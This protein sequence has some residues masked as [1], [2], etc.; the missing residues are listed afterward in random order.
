MIERKSDSS[1]MCQERPA[2]TDDTLLYS[3][4]LLTSFT[5]VFYHLKMT[6]N[7]E[8]EEKACLTA[9]KPQRLLLNTVWQTRTKWY[10]SINRAQS[11]RIYEKNNNKC[12]STM[13]VNHFLF[14]KR[15][16]SCHP[17]IWA[18]CIDKVN[19]RHMSWAM[20]IFTAVCTFMQMTCPSMMSC[21]SSHWITWL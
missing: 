14:F 9:D 16:L 17:V 2:S 19:W 13:L 5:L 3:C 7:R 1:Y 21:P 12:F 15:L 4:L 6:E 8:R 18:L 20:G 10:T 11:C